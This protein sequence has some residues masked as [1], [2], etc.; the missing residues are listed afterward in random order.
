MKAK[1]SIAIIITLLLIVLPMISV[2]VQAAT[3]GKVYNLTSEMKGNTVYFNW[4]N[5]YHADGYDIYI[6]TANK[7]YEY[8]GSVIDNVAA[9]IGFKESN[10]YK[11]KI[12]AYQINSNGKKE[13]GSFSNI[14]NVSTTTTTTLNK[15]NS[16]TA[17][18][19]GGNVTLNWSKI[20]NAT[21]YQVFVDIPN[22]G[23]VN[24]GA[25]DGGATSAIITGFENSKTYYFKVRA[26]KTLN[27]GALEYGAFSPEQKL[28]INT[29]K[30][31]EIVKP[32]ETKPAKVN[33]LYIDRVDENQASISWS[34]AANADG[35]E[36]YVSKSNGSY[37]Y[38]DTVYKTS[39]KLTNLSYDTNYKVA[40]NK[41]L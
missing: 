12:C 7:G 23:Y 18:Q 38:I 37:K 4:D 35:Y 33:N 25:V 30:Y 16:L 6:N 36:I 13:T 3:V 34:K 27:S 28:T 32:E 20:S 21:G 8:I 2:P 5:V 10:D 24:I 1:K 22:L 31:E 26:Y 40:G 17:S 29:N 19:N 41:I 9:I 11:A 14:I 15:V 39:A